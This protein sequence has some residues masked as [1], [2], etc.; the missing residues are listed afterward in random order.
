MSFL[1]AV[2]PAQAGAPVGKSTSA[3][4]DP[5]LRQGDNVKGV[6]KQFEAIFLR[7]MIAAMRTPSLGDDLF[8]SDAGKQFRDMSDA[9]LADAMA[10]KFGIA[11]LIEQQT[12]ATK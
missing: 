9:R 4:R 11:R 10:G 12:G 3:S 8:G 1:Q 6:A 2:T 7:Q 5:G